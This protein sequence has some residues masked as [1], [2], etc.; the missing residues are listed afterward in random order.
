MPKHGHHAWNREELA[1]Y[2]KNAADK[3]IAV[4]KQ[5]HALTL[6]TLYKT[7]L[8]PNKLQ[9]QTLSNQR[10]FDIRARVTTSASVFDLD[11]IS[12]A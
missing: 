8:L 6:Y 3:I 11:I 4:L 9:N 12:H 5:K 10:R 2:T 7:Q 1:V